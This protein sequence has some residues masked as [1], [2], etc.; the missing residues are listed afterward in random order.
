MGEEGKGARD[1][2]YILGLVSGTIKR[3]DLLGL[4]VSLWVS[5]I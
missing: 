5:A 1:S 3:C 2:L 4:G